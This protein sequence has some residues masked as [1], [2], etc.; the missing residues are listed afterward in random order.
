M[1]NESDCYNTLENTPPFSITKSEHLRILLLNAILIKGT[2]PFKC[3]FFT[4]RRGL[5]QMK[6]KTFHIHEAIIESL[7]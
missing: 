2:V 6:G 3:A 5:I 1:L 7:A 4:C